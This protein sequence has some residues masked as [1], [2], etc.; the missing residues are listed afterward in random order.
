MKKISKFKGDKSLIF[1]LLSFFIISVLSIGS[2]QN[3]LPSYMNGLVL[4][5][6]MWYGIGLLTILFI[7]YLGNEYIYKHIWFLYII[8]IILLVSLLIFARPINDA[9]CWFTFPGIGAFQ[10]SE[11]M[12]IILIITLGTLTHQFREQYPNPSIKAEFIFLIKIFLVVLIP[13]I[14]TFLQ[15][16]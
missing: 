15:P 13:S 7:T 8:G 5:Q 10:P 14:L 11:F 16:D 1:F 6:I 2:A 9:K 3:L 4:K 12:K